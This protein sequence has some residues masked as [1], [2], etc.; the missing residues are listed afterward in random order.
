MAVRKNIV[1]NLSKHNGLFISRKNVSFCRINKKI[2]FAS[3]Y[4]NKSLIP[5][6]TI[7]KL[8]Q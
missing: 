6:R 3:K 1:N 4:Y 7:S 5:F 2:T 8:K